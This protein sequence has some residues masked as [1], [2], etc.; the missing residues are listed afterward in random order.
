MIKGGEMTGW[1]DE[2]VTMLE[3]CEKRSERLTEWECGFVES[4]Q[5]QI[6]NGHQ[7]SAKQI[8]KLDSIWDRVTTMR[9]Q[10]AGTNHG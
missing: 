6:A 9:P 2:Y 8:E 3:D 10:T 7:P 5:R 1:V 4:L